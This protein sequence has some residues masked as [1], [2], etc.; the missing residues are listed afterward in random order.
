M[1]RGE[2]EITRATPNRLS[3]LAPVFGRAF[4]DEPMM[5]QPIGDRGDV[6]DRFTRCFAYFL[7]KALGLGII[8][9]AGDAKGAAAWVPPDLVDGWDDHPW[10]QPRIDA[11]TEDGGRRYNAFWEWIE[12]RSPGEPMWLLDSIAVVPEARGR[13]LGR[14]LIETGLARARAEGTGAFLSTGTPRNVSIYGRC[15]FRV[16]EDVDAPEGG[17]HIWFMRWDP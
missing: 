12:S 8:W 14:A 16:V 17:P 1:A 6:V 3:A 7:E 13:G 2:I 15:G 10:N 11:L 5:R 9:E 4:I